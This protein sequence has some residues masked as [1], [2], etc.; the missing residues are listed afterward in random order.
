MGPGALGV[1]RKLNVSPTQLIR[2]CCTTSA[3]ELVDGQKDGKNDDRKGHEYLQQ[4]AQEAQEEVGVKAT[5]FDKGLV[6]SDEE[7]D[8]P[9]PHTFGRGRNSFAFGDKIGSGTAAVLVS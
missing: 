3:T 7:R 4:H 8:G 2:T 5:F 1:V 6:R 9:L